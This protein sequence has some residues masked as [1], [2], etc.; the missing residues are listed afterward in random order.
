[1]LRAIE[2]SDNFDNLEKTISE[3]EQ[4]F[5]V[6]SSVRK[7]LLLKG[8]ESAVEK[9]L[10]DG[11]LNDTEEKRLVE[12]KNYFSLSQSDLDRNG[13]LT[14][15]AQ[16]AVLRDV[17]NG[18]IPQRVSVDGNLPINFQKGE[19]VIWAFSTLVI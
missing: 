3:I 4:S 17:L 9:F 5:F 11:I 13:A 12:F 16:A 18:I 10:E 19:Q 8:W 1:V 14:K 2:G 6:P 15:T 7:A